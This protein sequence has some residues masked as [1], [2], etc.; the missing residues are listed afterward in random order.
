MA[1]LNIVTEEDP[2]LRKSSREVSAIDDRTLRLIA[3]MKQTLAKSGGVG[4]AAVQ[5]GVLK[6]IFM[7]DVGDGPVVFINPVIISTEGKRE[8]SEGCL[9]CPGKWGLTQR[10]ETV[11]MEATDEKGERFTMEGHGLFAQAMIH[12]Y[13]HLDGKLFLDDVIRM[14]SE[15]ELDGLQ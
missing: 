10:P 7:I 5:V 13:N 9:S 3:D 14:L 8:V 2:I 15:D 6:R 4:L 1:L 12:E 11:V